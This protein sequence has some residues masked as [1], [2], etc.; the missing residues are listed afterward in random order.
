MLNECMMLY[1]SLK[2]MF[3][4]P[5]RF[6]KLPVHWGQSWGSRTESSSGQ[7]QRGSRHRTSLSHVLLSAGGSG[8]PESSAAEQTQR[9]DGPLGAPWRQGTHVERRTHHHTSI[10]KWFS[11]KWIWWTAKNFLC[12]LNKAS[13]KYIQ[14]INVYILWTVM[15]VKKCIFKLYLGCKLKSYTGNSWAFI[16]ITLL[17]VISKWWKFKWKKKRFQSWFE[18]C[19]NTMPTSFGDFSPCWEC[20]QH[21]HYMNWP[22]NLFW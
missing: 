17:K 5:H 1:T 20:N 11:G 7:S 6:G 8:N 18:I 10:S 15:S 13:A 4:L 16:N 3:R 9:G 22:L 14:I 12:T 19:Y 2:L 21:G